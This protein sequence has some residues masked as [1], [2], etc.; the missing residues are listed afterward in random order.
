MHDIV[1]RDGSDIISFKLKEYD[2]EIEQAMQNLFESHKIIKDTH[3]TKSKEC[4]KMSRKD[5][6]LYAA[7][8]LVDFREAKV[9][10]EKYVIE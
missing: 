2:D 8:K 6:L 5:L 10:I 7:L 1:M 4:L 9:F 3:L